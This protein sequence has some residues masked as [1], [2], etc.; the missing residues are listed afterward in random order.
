MRTL[1]GRL[2][3]LSGTGGQPSYTLTVDLILEA[4]RAAEPVVW[5]TAGPATFY[6]P[7]IA[8]AGVDLDAM[9]VIRLPRPDRIARAADKL[10]RSGAFG[11]IVLDFVDAPPTMPMPIMS[12]LVGLA[13]RHDTVLLCLTDKPASSPSLGSLISL[14]AE[15]RRSCIERN[16]HRCEIRVLKDK[17]RGP[18]WR[19]ATVYRGP[20]GL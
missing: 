16:L 2:V 10:A 20:P 8:S 6:A 15:A 9:I 14:R 17:R 3:E 12:R 4:Q 13:Q 7:D 19:H 11:L 18:G 5:V 1:S